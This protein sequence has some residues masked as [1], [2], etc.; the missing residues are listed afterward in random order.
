MRPKGEPVLEEK[1]T[2][3]NFLYFREW[4]HEKAGE[5]YGV[6]REKLAFNYVGIYPTWRF[7]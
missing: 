7:G 1:N 4:G 2:R 3:I 5:V 6:T